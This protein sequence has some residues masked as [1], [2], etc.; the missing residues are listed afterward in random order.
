MI[1]LQ[2]VLASSTKIV[3]AGPLSSAINMSRRRKSTGST[4]SSLKTG[5]TML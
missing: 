5:T 2:S 4:A 1:E 3:S